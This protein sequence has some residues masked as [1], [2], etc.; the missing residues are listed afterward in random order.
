MLT[1]TKL[2]TQRLAALPTTSDEIA[3]KLKELGCHGVPGRPSSCPIAKYLGEDA[4]V[5]VRDV[6]GCH[7]VRVSLPAHVQRFI[8]DFDDGDYPELR[9]HGNKSRTRSS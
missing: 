2:F 4:F 6:F 1:L 5:G 9:L 7:G 3:A 8:G